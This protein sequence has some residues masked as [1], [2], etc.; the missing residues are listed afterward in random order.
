[1]KNLFISISKQVPSIP[2][3]LKTQRQAV[4]NKLGLKHKGFG[5]YYDEKGNHFRFEKGSAKLV[6]QG[7]REGFLKK[8]TVK[9]AHSFLQSVK[10]NNATAKG[11]QFGMDA[12]L[13]GMKHTGFE[14]NKRIH[15][16]SG[17]GVQGKALLGKAKKDGQKIHK[18]TDGRYYLMNDRGRPYASIEFKGKESN[19]RFV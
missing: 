2:L 4:I 1:M 17:T 12:A 8:E 15:S 11:K 10:S 3:E 7:K 19:V 5:N 14:P 13:M 18:H 6:D 9:Q 16:F